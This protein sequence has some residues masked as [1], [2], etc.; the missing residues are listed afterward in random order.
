MRAKAGDI[1][2]SMRAS[3]KAPDAERIY[4]AGEKEYEI[5]KEREDSGVPINEAVQAEINEVRDKLGLSYTFPWEEN[6]VPYEKDE[7]IEAHI[8]N[9]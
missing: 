3:K 9:K 5:W 1:C 7:K 4:T 8:E 2:R 6:Y